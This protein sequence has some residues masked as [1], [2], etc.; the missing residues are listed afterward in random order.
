MAILTSTSSATN[1]W[2]PAD[3]LTSSYSPTWRS[4]AP[5]SV[6]AC[7]AWS[8]DS[9]GWKA[10]SAHLTDRGQLTPLIKLLPTGHRRAALAWGLPRAGDARPDANG[11]SN[12]NS[13]HAALELIAALDRVENHK[14][15]K[16]ELGL[17]ETVTA[18][19]AEAGLA[20]AAY[21]PLECIAWSRALPAL[22]SKLPAGLWWRLFSSLVAAAEGAQQPGEDN[23]LGRQWLTAELPLTLAYLFPEIAEAHQLA[24]A[25]GRAL[26]LGLEQT[27]APEGLPHARDVAN[28]RPLLG[29]WTRS[30]AMARELN[31]SGWGDDSEA[32]F[33]SFV[34]QTLRLTRR[35]GGAALSHDD[36]VKGDAALF[37]AALEGASREDWAIAAENVPGLHAKHSMPRSPV[38]SPA[39]SHEKACLA[40]LRSEW[41]DSSDRLTVTYNGTEVRT[42]LAVG[43]DLLWSGVW[44]LNISVDGQQLSPAKDACWE[45]VCW[46]SDAD[47]DFLELE[48]ELT[49]GVRVQRQMLLARQDRFLFMADAVLGT[50]SGALDYRCVLPLTEGM[51]FDPASETREGYLVGRKP[52][53]VVFPLSLPEWRNQPW[54]G[55]LT[56]STAGLELQC[57]HPAARRLYAPMFLDFN[58][59]RLVRPATWRRLTVAENREIVEH[60]DAVGYRVQSGAQQWMIYRSLADR[61][62]RTL[63]G[64]NL[65][66]EMLVARFKTSGEIEPLLEIE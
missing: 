42:E 2:G 31:K 1:G 3:S 64:Q 11:E 6:T 55:G 47:A 36:Y 65:V 12:A 25:G 56:S 53:A 66:S 39:A 44:T 19:L 26:L 22:A 10:W 62:N 50:T 32:R 16:G 27:L 61:G 40:I 52:R 21:F 63:L 8:D 18:W 28:V 17:T 5:K 33:A 41:T 35:D 51:T 45:E 57:G 7:E 20:S 9:P 4:D 59:K 43:R 38:A 37:V 24:I 46:H 54:R 34:R 58:P 48:I 15:W 30:R 23:P 29:V 60:E 49:G 13:L 14:S